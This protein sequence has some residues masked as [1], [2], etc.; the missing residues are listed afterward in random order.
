M[1]QHR[2]RASPRAATFADATT[3]ATRRLVGLALAL[4]AACADEPATSAD[5]ATHDTADAVADAGVDASED[6]VGGDDGIAG[7]GDAAADTATD[8]A[9]DAEADVTTD[10]ADAGPVPCPSGWA[11][12][13]RLLPDGACPRDCIEQ[14]FAAHCPGVVTHGVCV[15]GT[16]PPKRA[17]ASTSRSRGGSAI[18][19][20]RRTR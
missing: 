5:A 2:R 3:V 4:L 18:R 17:W 8:T 15:T 14:V 16:P 19:P 13:E 12:N 9:S 11:C 20:R 6:T 7:D 1:P 10:A